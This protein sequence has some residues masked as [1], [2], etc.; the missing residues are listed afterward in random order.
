MVEDEAI[1]ERY[2][3]FAGLAAGSSTAVLPILSY[4]SRESCYGIGG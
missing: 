3:L 4:R 1:L 2:P